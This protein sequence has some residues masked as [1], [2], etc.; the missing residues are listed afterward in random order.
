MAC[1]SPIIMQNMTRSVSV[2]V[3]AP[4]ENVWPGLRAFER[5]HICCPGGLLCYQMALT[6]P[7]QSGARSLNFSTLP[8][9]SFGSASINVTARGRL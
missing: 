1:Q 3:R 9:G 5:I 2:R 4:L 8:F 6:R 7:S